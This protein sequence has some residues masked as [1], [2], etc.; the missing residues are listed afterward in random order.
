MRLPALAVV[1]ATLSFLGACASTPP[2]GSSATS[3][4]A[5]AS[6]PRGA[7]TWTCPISGTEFKGDG[8]VAYFGM[9]EVHCCTRADAEQFAAMPPEK[10]ARLAAP[11]VLPQKKITNTTCPLTGDAL[12]AAAAPVTYEGVVIGFASLADANQF[13][14][15]PPAKQKD[16]IDR[17]KSTSASGSA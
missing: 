4:A 1:A 10:R 15:L 7:K 9:W 2:A 17:W 5:P 12:T 6:A 16:V 11:Q 14:S 3:A 13:R 8:Q